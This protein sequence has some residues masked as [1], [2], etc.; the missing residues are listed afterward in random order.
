MFDDNGDMRITK[1]TSVL[2]QKLQVSH[3]TRTSQQQVVITTLWVIN[4]P[5]NGNVQ[6]FV[7]EYIIIS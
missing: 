2:K 5:I 7:N 4:W 6:D 3:S 1:S